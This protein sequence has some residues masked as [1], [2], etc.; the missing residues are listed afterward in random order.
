VYE[1]SLVGTG[2]KFGVVVARFNELV[3]KLLLDGALGAFSRHGV[4]ADDIDVSW[5]IWCPISH[6]LLKR[7][8]RSLGCDVDTLGLKSIWA[9]HCPRLQLS[10]S[11]ALTAVCMPATGGLGAGQ[12]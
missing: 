3:T 2:M 8:F 7:Y 6:W 10:V 4:A 11:G 5:P 9:L 1:G 12:L